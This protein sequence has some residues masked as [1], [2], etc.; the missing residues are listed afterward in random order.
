MT[1]FV[2]IVSIVLP[3][4]ICSC[5]YLLRPICKTKHLE[6]EVEEEQTPTP[7]Q[8][9]IPT[10][11]QLPE[12]I[13]ID[14]EI[15]ERERSIMYWTG[16]YHNRDDPNRDDLLYEI[17]DPH[18]IYWNRLI[19]N[20]NKNQN[21]QI[22]AEIPHYNAD[23][24][25]WHNLA[26][27]RVRR[28]VSA[29]IL[30]ELRSRERRFPLLDEREYWAALP[31]NASSVRVLR[32]KVF[33]DMI[34]K[35]RCN[36]SDRDYWMSLP[37]QENPQPR[38]QLTPLEEI[39]GHLPHDRPVTLL[40]RTPPPRE[41]LI[42]WYKETLLDEH[43]NTV[44]LWT[45]EL[46]LTDIKALTVQYEPMPHVIV[47]TNYLPSIPLNAN[48]KYSF[49]SR[50][51]ISSAHKGLELTNFNVSQIKN[52]V[53]RQIARLKM[54]EDK[55]SVI[56]RITPDFTAVH[57][58]IVYNAPISCIDAKVTTSNIIQDLRLIKSLFVVKSTTDYLF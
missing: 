20:A 6:V 44:S 31:I 4:L 54:S 13:T 24:L 34:N 43:N 19:T 38:P 46:V 47:P 55:W 1:D 42:N 29:G 26:K 32:D 25:Y 49:I 45:R 18:R 22:L 53:N 17:R 7:T 30:D 56:F 57:L 16:I 21:A 37:V 10:Q 23:R 52:A 5:A 40:L 8:T 3:F 41:E 35:I 33:N 36:T 39:A 14:P 12:P 11:T 27:N 15:T 28:S 50:S 51:V 9:Q 58:T 2:L 48:Q